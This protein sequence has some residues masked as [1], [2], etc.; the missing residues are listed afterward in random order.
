G[1]KEWQ[2][3]AILIFNNERFKESDFESLMQI[4]V[5][6]KQNDNIEIGNID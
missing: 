4:R 6:E 1:F 3:P 2:G 5:C